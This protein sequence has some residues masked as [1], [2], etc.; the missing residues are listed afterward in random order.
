VKHSMR[1]VQCEQ[2]DDMEY[3]INSIMNTV[4]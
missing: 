2:G 3:I 1:S 4:M